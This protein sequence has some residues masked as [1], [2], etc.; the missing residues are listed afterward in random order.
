[1]ASEDDAV[2]RYWAL[3]PATFAILD[4]LELRQTHPAEQ[5]PPEL[6]LEMWLYPESNEYDDRYRLRL[7]FFGVEVL[8]LQPQGLVQFGPLAIKS[9]RDY[10]WE[11]LKYQVEDSESNQLSFYCKSFEARIEEVQEDQGDMHAS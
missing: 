9:M 7:S 4:K 8:K 11:H 1:M 6:S 2:D 10:G 3:R 5:L